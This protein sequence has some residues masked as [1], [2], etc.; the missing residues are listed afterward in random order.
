MCLAV[1]GQQSLPL[2]QYLLGPCQQQR[3]PLGIDEQDK[4]KS[5]LGYALQSGQN[6]EVIKTVS[7]CI[8]YNPGIR[9]SRMQFCVPG[10][11]CTHGYVSQQALVAVFHPLLTLGI[12]AAVDSSNQCA[13]KQLLE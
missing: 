8:V 3:P 6:E 5:A 10:F 9:Y 12:V 11:M 4:G 13:H 2:I 1:Q 7:T